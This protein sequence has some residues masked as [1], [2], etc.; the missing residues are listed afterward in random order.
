M[1]RKITKEQ[2]RSL[3]RKWQQNDQGLTYREFRKTVTPYFGD[4]SCVLVPW[5]GM[6]VGIEKDGYSHT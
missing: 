4:D 6:W 1:V 2:Q 5:C 3:L